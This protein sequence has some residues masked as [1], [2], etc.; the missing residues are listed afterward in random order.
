MNRPSVRLRLLTTAVVALL[1]SSCAEGGQES[2]APRSTRYEDLVALFEEWREFQRPRVVDGVPDYTVA[3]MDAQRRELPAYR[4]RLAA[5]DPSSWPVSQQVDYHIVRAEMNGLEFD[6]RVRRPWSRMPSF[7]KVLLPAETDVP[8]REGVVMHDAIELWTYR[9]PLSADRVSELGQRLRAIPAILEQAKG[10]LVENARDLWF[11]GIRTKESESRALADFERLAA[12]HHPELVADV[13]QARAAI[14]EFKRWLENELPGKTEPSGVG[15]ENYDWY[16]EN[17]QLVPYTWEEEQLLVQRELGRSWAYLKLLENRTRQMSPLELVASAEEY[18]RRYRQAVS[19]FVEFLRREEVFTVPDY[20]QA[21]LAAQEGSFSQ[22]RREFFTE[23]NYRDLRVMRTH[24]IHWLELARLE[25]EPH[26]SPIRRLPLL[27]NIWAQRAEGYATGMEEMMMAAGFLD[28]DPRTRELV[29]ILL[30]Q[31]AARAFA[32]LK[33]HS[34]EFTLEEA[35]RFAAQW[36]PRGWLAEDGNLVWFEQGLYLEQPGYG[37]S[38]VVG[39]AYIDKL[40]AERAHQ[41][42]DAFTL[43]RFLDEFH[44]GGLIPLSLVGWEMTGI[45]DLR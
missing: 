37:T 6:H 14:D 26:P 8:A 18:R 40:I 16:L 19:D 3:A 13:R 23:I 12:E 38:Y 44:A 27:Y 11:L 39:K 33:M 1:L 25:R 15:V 41:L 24:G 32:S 29:Y 31:R 21:A 30:A 17:V 20:A 43:R 9:L 10:N 42:G 34:N 28:D 5:I 22:G 7:Y 36:T 45:Q 2:E 4:R 35:I